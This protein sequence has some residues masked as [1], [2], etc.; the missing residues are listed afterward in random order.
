MDQLKYRKSQNLS[1][2][3]YF[4]I[5]KELKKSHQNIEFDKLPLLQ[6]MMNNF[7]IIT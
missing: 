5:K 7:T 3:S 2:T 1:Q 4:K 6:K